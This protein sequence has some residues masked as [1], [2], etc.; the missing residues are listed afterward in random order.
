MPYFRWWSTGTIGLTSEMGEGC[1]TEHQ[2]INNAVTVSML[3]NLVQ[4]YAGTGKTHLAMCLVRKL[5][6]RNL[7]Y[8][9]NGF[10]IW[11]IRTRTLRREIIIRLD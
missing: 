7:L 11:A 10:I 9:T 3:L 2:K 8:D 1:M 4:A 5:L 6:Q